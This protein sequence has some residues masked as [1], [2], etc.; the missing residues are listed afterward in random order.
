MLGNA[1]GFDPN[2]P[3]WANLMHG[4]DQ[5]ISDPYYPWHNMQGGIKGMP[6]HPAAYQGM[7]ITLAPSALE[8]V[9]DGNAKSTNTSASTP[10]ATN[11]N[12]LPTAGSDF[13]FSQESKGLDFGG[14]RGCGVM[15]TGSSQATPAGEGF[16]DNFI[17]GGWEDGVNDAYDAGSGGGSHAGS[18]VAG[19]DPAEMGVKRD[20]KFSWPNCS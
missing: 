15:A 17:D 19:V 20:D 2:D 5:Y 16:W 11:T 3:S 18:V 9:V 7:S 8:H 12:A 1:P 6:V 10:A 4:A 13:N 14:G